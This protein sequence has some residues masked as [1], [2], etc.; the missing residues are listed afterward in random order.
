MAASARCG[1]FIWSWKKVAHVI[2]YCA[3]S[4]GAV[5]DLDQNQNPKIAGCCMVHYVE[6]KPK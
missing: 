5:D 3:V 6:L 4:V 2:F 1:P